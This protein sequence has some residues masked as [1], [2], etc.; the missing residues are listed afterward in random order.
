MIRKLI[1][2]PLA[3][4]LVIFGASAVLYWLGNGGRLAIL[5]GGLF[6]ASLGAF[7]IKEDWFDRRSRERS[8]P[9]DA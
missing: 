8:P 4:G 9:P 5:V 7:W 1:G 2:I 3:C 6:A